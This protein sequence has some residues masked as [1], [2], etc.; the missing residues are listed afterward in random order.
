MQLKNTVLT[1]EAVNKDI[2]SKKNADNEK[3]N[4]LRFFD[5]LPIF[6]FTTSETKCGC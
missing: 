2:K 4:N 3:R 5:A 6:L 1:I